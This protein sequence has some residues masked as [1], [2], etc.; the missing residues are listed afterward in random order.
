MA[1][2]NDPPSCRD[3]LINPDAC[4]ASLGFRLPNADVVDRRE[5]QPERRTANDQRESRVAFTG[6]R[7]EMAQAPHREHEADMPDE[8]QHARIGQRLR[9]VE[10]AAA[11]ERHDRRRETAGHHREPGLG[12]REAQHALREQREE[13]R[14]AVQP[15]AEHDEEEDRRRRDRGSCSTRKFDDRMLVPR[16]QL[17]P[18]ERDER[19]AETMRS[20]R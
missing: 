20:A 17:P 12:R 2:P 1:M 7:R 9:A 14:S 6:S 19:E 3:R 8:D 13:K 15:E 16:R 18:Q 4:C 11:D 10:Q 5:E